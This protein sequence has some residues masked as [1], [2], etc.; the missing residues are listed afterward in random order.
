MKT[1]NSFFFTLLIAALIF[2]LPYAQ[3]ETQPRIPDKLMLD[4]TI[5]ADGN[6][7]LNRDRLADIFLQVAIPS[8]FGKPGGI[9]F[10]PLSKQ[11]RYSDF[12]RAENFKRNYPWLYPYLYESD[13]PALLAVNKWVGPIRISLGLPNNYQSYGDKNEAFGYY[14]NMGSNAKPAYQTARSW[15]ENEAS[16]LAP[17]LSGLTGLN[18]EFTAEELPGDPASVSNVRIILMDDVK[19]WETKF[20]SG[21]KSVSASLPDWPQSWL[22]IEPHLV[23]RIPFTPQFTR[24]VD[25]YFISNNDNQIQFAVCY[26]WAGHEEALIRKLTQECLVRSLGFSGFHTSSHSERISVLTPWNGLFD[27]P[28]LAIVYNSQLTD[29]DQFLIKTLYAPAIKPGMPYGDALN[30]LAP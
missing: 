6:I 5:Y 13:P 1:N 16:H 23:T 15:V 24:Q 8:S 9:D 17:T 18:I 12:Y 11:K 10:R 7:G 21:G 14:L 29:M 28:A 20:K 22:A 25:G 27:F 26:I 4:G 19:W 3:A 2:A 30:L